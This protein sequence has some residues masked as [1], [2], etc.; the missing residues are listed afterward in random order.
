MAI[1]VPQKAPENLLS[2][3]QESEQGRIMSYIRDVLTPPLTIFTLTSHTSLLNIF[4][5]PNL[6]CFQI[7]LKSLDSERY[8]TAGTYVAAE[9]G[10][11]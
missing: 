5:H 7:R 6:L 11:A 4:S 1:K 3:Y 9:F 2:R 10:V 8:S